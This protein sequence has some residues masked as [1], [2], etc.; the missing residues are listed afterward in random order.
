MMFKSYFLLL[1]VIA[2]LTAVAQSSD[3]EENHEC[4]PFDDARGQTSA[5]KTQGSCKNNICNDGCCRYHTAFLTCDTKNDYPHQPCICNE[6]TNNDHLDKGEDTPTGE[7]TGGTGVIDN[8]PPVNPPDS[9]I[10]PD[11]NA[12]TIGGSSCEDG[13]QYQELGLPYTNCSSGSGCAGVLDDGRPTCC[14]R[15]F[16]FCGAFD[17]FSAECVE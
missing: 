6:L 13:S 16:C 11:G 9:P 7:G 5:A 15:H 3:I 2:I 12:P 14:K 17:I 1:L 10:V 4:Y 8:L